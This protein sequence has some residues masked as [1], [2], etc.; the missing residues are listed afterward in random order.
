MSPRVQGIGL[1]VSAE[2]QEV[3]LMPSRKEGGRKP[4]KYF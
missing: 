3:F 2:A 1:A 4:K